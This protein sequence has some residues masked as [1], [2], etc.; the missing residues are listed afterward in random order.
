MSNMGDEQEE[1]QVEH[2]YTG[3]ELT[4]E[5][6]ENLQ[7]EL[8]EEAKDFRKK[9]RS[10]RYASG[11][12]APDFVYLIDK[13]WLAKWKNY[14][15]YGKVKRGVDVSYTEAH[16]QSL[17]PGEI[18]NQNLLKES[19]K[20]LSDANQEDVSNFPIKT[21]LSEGTDYKLLDEDTWKK[22]QTKYGGICIKRNKLND[23]Y[24]KKYD[25]K[26][27]KIPLLVLPPFPSL[28]PEELQNAKTFIFLEKESTYK[29]FH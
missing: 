17:Y 15:Q 9:S 23:H 2:E 1:L 28:S 27:Q 12:M 26:L 6:I 8:K 7:K 13:A 18:S 25:V 11:Y 21:K 14:V 16:L 22:I 5:T 20:Y 24:F 3:P 29:D 19:T 4:P 10:I